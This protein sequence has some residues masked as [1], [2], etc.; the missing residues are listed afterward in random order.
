[1]PRTRKSAAKPERLKALATAAKDF[2][3]WKPGREVLTPVA[4]VPTIF[5]QF[6]V[7]T[8]VRGY[9]IQRVVFLHGPSSMGK[10]SMMLGLGRSFL[11]HGHYYFHV[12]AEMT[13][14][15]PWVQ[16]NLGEFADS[17]RFFAIRPE[18]FEETA[19]AVR[20]AAYELKRKR[21][22]GEIEANTTA[23][24]GIDSLQKLVPKD[25][26][27]KLLEQSK[28]EKTLDPLKGRGGMFQAALN[29]AWMRELIPLL[30]HCNAGL[31][32]LGRESQ[33]V[34][35]GMFDKDYVVGGGNSVYYDS[36]LV[37]RIT[38]DAWVEQGSDKEKEVIGERHLVQIMKT[39]VGHKDAKVTRCYFHTS[40][41][42]LIPAGYDR[43]RDVIEL[44]LRTGVL[45]LS[46]KVTGSKGTSVVDVQTGDV[47][48]TTVNK[49]VVTLTE[50][51]D[52]LLELTLRVL[53]VAQPEEESE[54]AS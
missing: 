33:N 51:S 29:T 31:V 19:E 54:I 15:E 44:G 39:K 52:A 5:P 2:A 30:Y 42:K 49:A 25:L 20:T 18:S 32:L 4:S 38:R 9:P 48:G 47:Y 46:G 28:N 3:L 12:D 10:T 14:P 17:D 53:D 23:L 34:N 7:A 43:A 27:K 24:F 26:L 13:T 37:C 16:E 1:M 45:Q 21:D 22:A 8:R 11:E 41:G 36:S 35:A 50:D 6:D 40:N